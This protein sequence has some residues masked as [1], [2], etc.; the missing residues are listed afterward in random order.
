MT[1]FREFHEVWWI[2]SDHDEPWAGRRIAHFRKSAPNGDLVVVISGEADRRRVGLRIWDDVRAREGWIKVKQ[3]EMPSEA[4][5]A[6]ALTE[7]R[8]Q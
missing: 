5:I 7:S 3:I 6:R 4:E 2:Y 1:D 8:K